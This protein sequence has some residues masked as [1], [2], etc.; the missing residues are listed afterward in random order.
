MSDHT[1]I[2]FNSYSSIIKIVVT[3]RLPGPCPRGSPRLAVSRM[4]LSTSTSH[5][6]PLFTRKYSSTPKFTRKGQF[7]RLRNERNHWITFSPLIHP[8]KCIFV[9]MGNLKICDLSAKRVRALSGCTTD[10]VS[11]ARECKEPPKLTLSANLSY[12]S[13][14][15]TLRRWL[16]ALSWRTM[17][18]V[19]RTHTL[20][21]W[22]H[23]ISCISMAKHVRI[24]ASVY[25][26]RFDAANWTS[27]SLRKQR[28]IARNFTSRRKQKPWN[29]CV[30]ISSLW[31][32][33]STGTDVGK[34][35]QTCESC[36]K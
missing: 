14:L 30:D 1:F 24:C 10:I 6:P 8:T 15:R 3:C 36:S 33:R 4:H 17:R 31:S 23:V 22:S 27:R 29:V 2:L 34:D 18:T 16:H 5:V 19:M 28:A 35:L 26:T 9:F 11:L 13:Y 20:P 12:F 32:T 21:A 7:E 25:V